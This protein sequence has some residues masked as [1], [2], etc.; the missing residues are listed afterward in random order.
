MSSRSAVILVGGA[1]SRM[2]RDKAL[3]EVQDQPAAIRL[4]RLLVDSGFVN[5]RLVGGSGERFRD[6]GFA[7]VPDL[8]Q[9]R[10]P[11]EGIRTSLRSAEEEWTLVVA[12]DLIALDR[13]AI[14]ELKSALE[15]H[16]FDDVILA[17]C[18]E[19]PQPLFA[20]WRRSSI[21]TIERSW[22][23]RG[24]LCATSSACSA[25]R[26]WSFRPKCSGT[27]IAPRTSVSLSG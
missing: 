7:H 20:W 16:P 12:V 6:C 21:Q 9:D 26:R 2:G 22:R 10:G 25:W 1:S 18:S 3:M 11:L 14:S 27:P 17:S 5:V 24:A 23:W 19:G 8:E 15:N 13:E 4:A